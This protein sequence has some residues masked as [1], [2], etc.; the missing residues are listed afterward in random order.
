[1]DVAPTTSSATGDSPLV[2]A[3]IPAFNRCDKT[4]GFLH[5]F[6]RVHYP[7]KR[8][9]ITDDGSRDNTFF[10]VQL[11]FP[12]VVV[13]K[14]DGNLWWSGG[15]NMGAHHAIENGADFILTINDDIEMSPDFLDRMMAVARQ[16]PKYIV[17]CRIHRQDSRDQIWAVGTTLYMKGPEL[18]KLNFANQ[19]WD[20]VKDKVPNP[21]A[22]DCM[23]GNGVL[24]PRSVFETVGFYDARHMPHYHADS[25]LLLRARE[26]GYQPVIATDAVLYNHIPTEPLV[27]NVRDLIFSK[28]SDRYWRAIRTTLKRHAPWG[29]RTWML[30][31]QYA[32]FICPRWVLNLARKCHRRRVRD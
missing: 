19:T 15:T 3:V 17:G 8:V 23:P 4:L 6:R 16:N 9:V 13:L 1:M 32:E 28:K 10:N 21:Y 5:Q 26:H 25:D 27:T 20:D 24:I 2:Y 18:F 11:N 29:S 31:C 7:N 30:W 12:E 22:V 14:G